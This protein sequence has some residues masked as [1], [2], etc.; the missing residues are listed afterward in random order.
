M[1]NPWCT[2]RIHPFKHPKSMPKEK[3]EAL[4]ATDLDEFYVENNIG[5]SGTGKNPTK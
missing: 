2:N 3:I 1:K 4:A 5:H